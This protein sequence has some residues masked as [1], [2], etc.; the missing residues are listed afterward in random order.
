VALSTRQLR[1]RQSCPVF[2]F[3]HKREWIGGSVKRYGLRRQSPGSSVAL[4]AEGIE[5]GTSGAPVVTADGR[6]YGIVSH[7]TTSHSAGEPCGGMPVA[8]MALPHWVLT[9]IGLRRRRL[10]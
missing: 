1:V 4:F 8:H 6:L 5:S 9:R 7:T 2:I 3:T 10:S